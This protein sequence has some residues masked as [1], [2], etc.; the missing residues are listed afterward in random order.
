MTAACASRSPHSR[1]KASASTQ[2]PLQVPHS[3]SAMLPTL[4]IVIGTLQRGH[5]SAAVSPSVCRAV[6]EPQCGQ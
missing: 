4:T 3:A 5:F 1:S 6:W 2:T